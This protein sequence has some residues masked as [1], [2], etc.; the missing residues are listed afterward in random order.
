MGVTQENSRL[1]GPENH[2]QLPSFLKRIDNKLWYTHPDVPEDKRGPWDYVRNFGKTLDNLRERT[3]L[4]QFR[5]LGPQVTMLEDLS[6]GI[7]LK[8]FRQIT[9]MANRFDFN[10]LTVNEQLLYISAFIIGSSPAV[11]LGIKH[12]G[13]D[14]V[15]LAPDRG[16]EILRVILQ[17]KGVPKENMPL[18]QDSRIIFKAGDNNVYTIALKFLAPFNDPKNENNIIQ[19]NNLKNKTN[20][21]HIDDCGAAGGTEETDYDVWSKELF[22]PQQYASVIGVS[23]RRAIAR[24]TQVL[25]HQL[26]HVRW[27]IISAAES[28]EM[29]DHFYLGLTEQEQEILQVSGNMRVNDMGNGM[30]L[31]SP[32]MRALIPIFKTLVQHPEIHDH[33]MNLIS[34]ALKDPNGINKNADKIKQL[35]IQK[36]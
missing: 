32:E 22:T 18:Y 28:N 29:N 34:L 20:M 26:T 11:D 25:N 9:E 3:K 7:I 17:A 31:K 1:I 23:V 33:V 24:R 15:V 10:K 14:P 4:D 8:P 30:S 35:L 12:V 27:K 21:L 16:G 2:I 36:S 5:H 6:Q 19:I 13:L